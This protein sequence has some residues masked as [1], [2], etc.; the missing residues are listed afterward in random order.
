MKKKIVNVLLM[1]AVVTSMMLSFTACGTEKSNTPSSASNA[2]ASAAQN[3]TQPTVEEKAP[4]S[5]T[6]DE[7]EMSLQ[8]WIET[9][10]C[11]AFID[12][13]NQGMEGVKV[14]F[15]AD[16]D[17]ISLV[18]QYDEQVEVAENAE[19]TM[20]ALIGGNA[21]VFEG[22]RDQLISETGNEN[23]VL[24]IEYRNADDSV[25]FSQDF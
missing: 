16:G 1:T 22:M 8:D 3:A 2:S 15:E 12:S 17:V 20:G 4:E 13:M 25:I 23:T 5:T 21:S 6:A 9:D 18:Y 24:R 14:F 11:K 10:E 19:E 7:G